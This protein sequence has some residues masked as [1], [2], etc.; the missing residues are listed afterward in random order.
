[1]KMRPTQWVILSFLILLVLHPVFYF[2]KKVTPYG[3]LLID[4]SESMKKAGKIKIDSPVA[5]K[6]NSFGENEEGTDI[7]NALQQ[8][9]KDHEDASLIILYSDGSNT[10]GKNPIEVASKLEIPVYFIIPEL[11]EMTGFISV[12]GPSLVR[13]G[14]SVKLTVYYKIPEEA[15]LEMKYN[16]EI[17]RRNIKKEGV[18]DFSFLPPAGKITIQFYLLSENDTL[19]KINWSLD[20]KRTHKLLIIEEVPDWN[21]KFFLRYFEDRGWTVNIHKGDSV[22]Y[23]NLN[24]FNMI[25]F[26]D[27]TDKYK[28]NIENYLKIGGNIL[29]IGSAP[30]NLNFLPVVAPNLT[31]YS[32]ELPESYYLKPGGIRK[33]AKEIK[34]SGENV[35]YIMPFGKGIVVQ[36]T[37]LELWKLA[38]SAKQLYPENF[39][40]K[41][42][43][44]LLKELI[45]DVVSISYSKKLLEGEDFILQFGE[46]KD[47]AKSFF[48]DRQKLPVT[49]DS[50]T[51]GNPAKGLHHFK[52]ELPSD[53]IKDS[54]LVVGESGDRMGIDTL[55]LEGIGTMSGGGRWDKD[56]KKETLETK[57]REIWINLRHNW[58]FISLLLLLLF[59]DWILWM[60]KN[61]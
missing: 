14:D 6:K 28:E 23:K 33:N 16:E 11:E 45:K 2:N 34:I 9:V 17:E 19:D 18:S 42:M 25:C 60:K 4:G 46:Q 55:M 43:D 37:Y 44:D 59:S 32:G 52:I 13:E 61:S 24:D 35:G 51:V 30:M 20:V 48:W 22:D 15:T 53:T 1:M 57:E 49:G 41:L 29:V 56:F 54:V 40:E 47:N 12:Y 26:L 58:L 21:H 10:K 38:L 27:N 39:F 36:F 5:L 31:K 8:V 7:G 50:V 3:I